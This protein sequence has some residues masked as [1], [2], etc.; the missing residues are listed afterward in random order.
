[1]TLIRRNGHWIVAFVGLLSLAYAVGLK[2]DRISALGVTEAR[3]TQTAQA[4]PEAEA[5]SSGFRHA[6]RAALPA[7]VSIEVRGKAQEHQQA[8]GREVDPDD[9]FQGSPFGEMFKNDPRLKE[10]FRRAP[11][12]MPR[13]HGMGSGFV[14]DPSGIVLTANH[15][16]A[17][18]ESVKVKL[19]DGREFMAT[20]VKTDPRTDVAI[21]RIEPDGKLPAIRLGNSDVLEIGDWVLA[22]GSPFGLDATVTAG[23]ISAKGRGP[24]ITERED[25]LQTDAAINPGNSGGPL[26][27]LTGEVIGINTAISTRSGGYDGVGFAIPINLAKWVADQLIEKGNVTRAYIGVGIQ[28]VDSEL[29]KQFNVPV[30]KGAIVTQVFPDSPAAAAKVEPGDLVLKFDGKDVHGSRELQGIVER[31]K[32]GETYPMLIV[33]DGK[34]TTLHVKVKEMP[35]EYSLSRNTLVPDRAAPE[36]P[37][38]ES[39]GDLGIE[40]EPASAELLQKLGYKADTKGVMISSVKEDSP[41]AQLGLREGMV[42]E[43]VGAKRVSSPAE[44]R[45]A[46][47]SMSLDKGIRMLVGTPRGA[48]FVVVHKNKQ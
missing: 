45:E 31:L 35:H 5:L 17:N 27:N 40:I 11:Q 32:A 19:H 34:E 46:V 4:P 14:I 3:E 29:A 30:G 22:I 36:T 24:R 8:N 37:K 25:F 16:V 6:A 38:A 10:F 39:F 42:I 21:V 13:T 20:D 28:P 41:A 18:A 44:F 23:I 47:K 33:R 12:Q 9:L 7:M 15:V 2:T 48:Q 1:M 43:M 26:I